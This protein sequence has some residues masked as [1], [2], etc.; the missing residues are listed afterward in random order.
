M[1]YVLGNG[2]FLGIVEIRGPWIN[3]K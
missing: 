2:K 3:D 1:N